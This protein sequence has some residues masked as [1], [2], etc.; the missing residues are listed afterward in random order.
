M[1]QEATGKGKKHNPV[2]V[3]ILQL[4]FNELDIMKKKINA[5]KSDEKIEY[6]L[7]KNTAEKDIEKLPKLMIDGKSTTKLIARIEAYQKAKKMGVVDGWISKTGGTLKALLSDAK[8]NSGTTRMSYIRKKIVSPSGT[9]SIKVD[10]VAILYEKQ[11]TTLS[12]ENKQNMKQR[13]HLEALANMAKAQ[14]KITEKKLQ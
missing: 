14:E 13:T 1:I 12:A 8:V 5:G 6:V 4:L 7:S 2:D 10:N 9:N 11:F 3:V